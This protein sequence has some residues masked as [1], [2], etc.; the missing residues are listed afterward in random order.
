[1]AGLAGTGCENKSTL[2]DCEA[3][4]A[5]LRR[6]A[7]VLAA[8]G[9]SFPSHDLD[10]VAVLSAGEAASLPERPAIRAAGTVV[11]SLREVRIDGLAVARTAAIDTDERGI[12]ALHRALR[13]Q[14]APA[15]ASGLDPIGAF[16]A[17]A[18]KAPWRAVRAVAATL[19]AAGLEEVG[20]FF[21][22][23]STAAAPEISVAEPVIARLATPYAG[24]LGWE[25]D[26]AQRDRRLAPLFGD[27][28][29]LRRAPERADA[30]AGSD[31][32]RLGDAIASVYSDAVLTCDCRVDLEAI[33]GLLWWSFGRRH[34]KGLL[35]VVVTVALSG[36]GTAIAAD[37][38]APWKQTY[39]LI[40]AAARRA[41]K[42]A[43][44]AIRL[45]G[46]GATGDDWPEPPPGGACGGA[47]GR[48]AN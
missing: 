18:P 40:L 42:K 28:E 37:D 13:Q 3:R 31:G 47:S 12:P 46:D 25:L 1:V 32:S 20:F 35:P 6:W 26:P 17:V 14:L 43:A 7:G 10:R 45:L 9:H 21:A 22:T 36:S 11:I 23:P 24:D 19:R 48:G 4:A 2:S 8:E 15:C 27:C 33:K 38:G 34:S 29:P 39:R 16:V 30:L 44:P 41:G 5:E